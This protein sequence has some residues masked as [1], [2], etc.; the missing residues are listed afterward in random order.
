MLSITECLREIKVQI[1][2]YNKYYV[3]LVWD[4]RVVRVLGD[5]FQKGWRFFFLV[6]VGD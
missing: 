1:P 5:I 6:G 2:S 4:N 3:N